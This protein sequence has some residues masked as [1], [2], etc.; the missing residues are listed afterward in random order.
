[1]RKIN[2]LLAST[3][4]GSLKDGRVKVHIMDAREY[5]QGKMESYGVIIIDFPDPV[6]PV[7]SSL[8][9]KELFNE[10]RRHLDPEGVMVC[11]ANS[12]K[13]TPRV[14]WSIAGTLNAAGL[15]TKAYYTVV[16]SFG[17]WGFHLASRRSL[18]KKLPLITVPHQAIKSNLEPLFNLPPTLQPPEKGLIINSKYDLRLH[19]LYLEEV[20][21]I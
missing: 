5:L 15:Q 20:E 1:L 18:T 17:V 11:Q 9:T 21:E 12:P 7:A 6:N 4:A 3:N 8:Y 16:P 2:R 10:A 13:N 14:F 19:N